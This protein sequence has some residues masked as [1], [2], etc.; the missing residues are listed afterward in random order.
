MIKEGFD[1][2]AVGEN[3]KN[4]RLKR[5]MTQKMLAEALSVTQSHV[6]QFERGA[7]VSDALLNLICEKLNASMDELVDGE[8]AAPVVITEPLAPPDGCGTDDADSKDSKDSIETTDSAR[9]TLAP[10]I[11]DFNPISY[12]VDKSKIVVL[13]DTAAEATGSVTKRVR[14]SVADQ[15]RM[16]A[17]DGNDIVV[18]TIDLWK[19]STGHNAAGPDAAGPVLKCITLPEFCS[20]LAASFSI[21]ERGAMNQIEAVKERGNRRK[22]AE[23]QDVLVIL[24]CQAAC[25]RA[26]GKK[27]ATVAAAAVAESPSNARPPKASP[28]TYTDIG[29]II[30]V[31]RQ[32]WDYTRMPVILVG[33]AGFEEAVRGDSSASRSLFWRLAGVGR[34]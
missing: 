33:S 15:I 21:S 9:R 32:V 8:L 23:Y 13:I 25:L 10:A 20:T 3:I 14:E 2:K 28:M 31:I 26:T 7:T 6:S 27:R 16:V 22:M 19:T 1:Y 18:H 5:N 24:N 12:A 11:T 34:M 4:L 17:G 30:T 29:D